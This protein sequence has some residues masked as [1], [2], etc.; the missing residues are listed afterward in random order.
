MAS[1]P[2]APGPGAM[3]GAGQGAEAEAGA[4]AGRESGAAPRPSWQRLMAQAAR[5]LAASGIGAPMRDAR[6]LMAAAA[7]IAPDRALLLA[8]EPAPPDQ[9]ARFAALIE[10]RCAR[11]PV[12]H[13]LG[14]RA[15]F[16][17]RFHVGPEVLDPRPETEILVRAA[18]AHP[19]RHLLDLGTGSGCILLSLLAERPEA[20]GVGVDISQDALRIAAR[21][22]R[23]LGLAQ[24]ARLRR[25]DWGA[26][27]AERF[28]LIVSNPPYVSTAEM[29]ALQPEVA[30]HEPALALHGGEDGLD[31]L[32]AILKD[33]PRLLAPG[34]RLIVEIGPTQGADAVALFA[35][36]GLRAVRL[37]QDLDGRDRIVMGQAAQM[38]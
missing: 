30:R 2:G 14:W 4:E 38:G 8:P 11:E 33:A 27:L 29:S 15:F 1:E 37:G 12:S 35:A 16:G 6:A 22:A 36:A 28:D 17:R 23:D 26:G 7:G 18:L 21:N 20:H 34:G 3:Q 10:R 19:F 13:L 31:P 32:R 24:R 5:R 25:G 9:A